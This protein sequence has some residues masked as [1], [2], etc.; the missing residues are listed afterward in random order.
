LEWAKR[1]WAF[2]PREGIRPTT[3]GILFFILFLFPGF[4]FKITV[5]FEFNLSNTNAQ[6]KRDHHDAKI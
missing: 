6:T 2:R 5:G 1:G 3:Q 4:K